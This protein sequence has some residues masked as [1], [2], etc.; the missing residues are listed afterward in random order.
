[1]EE[2]EHTIPIE[3]LLEKLGVTKVTSGISDA[4][5]ME[6]LAKDGYN[7]PAKE[8]LRASFFTTVHENLMFVLYC[9]ILTSILIALLDKGASA[10]LSH[11]FLMSFTFVSFMLEFF[12]TEKPKIPNIGSLVAVIRNGKSNIVDSK[13]LVRG[14]IVEIEQSMVVPADIRIIKASNLLVNGS[15]MLGKQGIRMGDSIGGGKYLESTN[16]VFQGF[17]I[18]TGK[19]IGV[20]LQTGSRTVLSQ[21]MSRKSTLTTFELKWILILLAIWLT[22]V[23]WQKY[24]RKEK[25]YA[26]FLVYCLSL[27]KFPDLI[28]KGRSLSLLTVSHLMINHQVYPKT[29]IEYETLTNIKYIMYD[30]RDVLITNKK[31]IRKAYVSDS[32]KEISHLAKEGD[33]EKLL[34]L[35]YYATYKEKVPEPKPEEVSLEDYDPTPKEPEYEH[36]IESTL[37]DFISGYNIKLPDYETHSKIPLTSKNRNS[38]TVITPKDSDPISILLGEAIDVLK[39]CKHM[40]VNGTNIEL[41]IRALTSLCEELTLEGNVCIGVGFSVIDPSVIKEG[42]E[43]TPDVFEFVLAGVFVIKE[44]T[45]DARL[46]LPLAEE[47]GITTIGIGRESKDYLLNISYMSNLL[48]EPP[49]DYK[50]QKASSWDK[51][52]FNA[53]HVIKNYELLKDRACFIPTMSVF[54]T[55]YLINQMKGESICYVG[56]NHV[57]LQ[58]SDI[59][60]SLISSPKDIKDSSNFVLLSATPLVDLLKCIKVLRGFGN[61]NF[62]FMQEL[63]GCLIPGLLYL[64]VLIVINKKVSSL[65]ILLIDFAVPLTS[66]FLWIGFPN[67]SYPN[68]LQS[69]LLVAMSGLY[70]YFNLHSLGYSEYA[71]N[72]G[73]FFTVIVVCFIKTAWLHCWNYKKE[74]IGWV[75]PYVLLGVK[76]ILF[77]LFCLFSIVSIKNDLESIESYL[78]WPG[79]LFYMIVLSFLKVYN[80]K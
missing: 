68:P 11:L 71:C 59:G 33:Y 28:K 57:A 75:F 23:L 76:V 52:M 64:V 12:T 41:P 10:S 26:G 44:Y 38:L 7:L 54:D 34:N 20:V 3:L 53:G 72:Y 45:E 62:F 69:W 24:I 42:T 19:G 61:H 22:G 14:D 32:L 39:N 63:I 25:F 47:L 15:I 4:V 1:M 17:T 78:I 49:V 51:V 73:Y 29:V 58:I 65:G 79:V 40:Y 8:K 16:M 6:R 30:I 31:E 66:Q 2:I 21:N 46:A 70:N 56:Q 48:T 18:E 27:T 36:A 37:R 9:A 43:L 35:A 5:L 13:F 60:V 80:L 74:H 55:A 50:T 67:N 77:Y